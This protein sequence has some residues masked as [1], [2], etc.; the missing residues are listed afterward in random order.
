M[1]NST[2][3]PAGP[4]PGSERVQAQQEQHGRRRDVEGQLARPEVAEHALHGTGPLSARCTS[5]APKSSCRCTSR[6]ARIRSVSRAIPA[7]IGISRAG[8]GARPPGCRGGA[9]W[10]RGRI[11]SHR[12]AAQSGRCLPRRWCGRLDGESPRIRRRL[13]IRE[14]RGR[15]SAVESPQVWRSAA[16]TSG[17][18]RPA[19]TRPRRRSV[20]LAEPEPSRLRS[21]GGTDFSHPALPSVLRKE[22]Q[23]AAASETKGAPRARSPSRTH[24]DLLDPQRWRHSSSRLKG[25]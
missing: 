18:G 22:V 11:A 25:A 12:R 10:S 6:V 16:F 3:D 8:C 13:P 21:Y 1:P 24:H 23:R 5:S 19:K 14:R 20:S 2:H 4:P 9:P 7:V 17:S 15:R